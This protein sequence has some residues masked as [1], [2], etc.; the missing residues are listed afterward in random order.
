M[1]DITEGLVFATLWAPSGCVRGPFIA[2]S[3]LFPSSGKLRE[4]IVV[5]VI[6]SCV[7]PGQGQGREG[8]EVP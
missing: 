4:V 8:G 3:L 2:I 6:S 5:A 7:G 1:F